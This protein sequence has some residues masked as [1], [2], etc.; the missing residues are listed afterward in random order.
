MAFDYET[1]TVSG[2]TQLPIR[3]PSLTATDNTF[4]CT[5]QKLRLN[6]VCNI[7]HVHVE[8]VHNDMDECIELPPESRLAS[9]MDYAADKSVCPIVTIILPSV[10]GRVSK[11]DQVQVRLR[12]CPNVRTV[13]EFVRALQPYH[14]AEDSVVQLP[15][16]ADE[17]AAIVHWTGFGFEPE[18]LQEMTRRLRCRLNV[19]WI[20]PRDLSRKTLALVGGRRHLIAGSAIYHAARVLGVDLVIIDKPGHW[21]Q[22]ETMENSKH[23]K[24]FLETDMSEDKHLKDRILKSIQEYG[25][26]IHGIFTHSDEFFLVVAHVANVLGLP[27][28]PISALTITADKHKSRLMQDTPGQT[29]RVRSLQQLDHLLETKSFVPK[30]P[31]I[32]KPTKGWASQCVSKVTS[33]DDLFTAVEKAMGRHC[34]AAVIEPF[35]DGPEV[36][37]NFVLLNGEVL[38]SEVTDERPCEADAKG[39]SV[40]ATFTSETLS[41]PSALPVNEVDLTKKEI[42]NIL[43][44]MGFQTGVFHAEARIVNSRLEYR[45]L[46]EDDNV[47]D[48][49]PKHDNN[50]PIADA[51][52]RLLEVNTRPP[53]FSVSRPTRLVYGIDYFAVDILAVLGEHDR[54]RLAA[55]PF[56]FS[57]APLVGAPNTAQCWTQLLCIS[58]P[59]EGI[60]RGKSP[61]AKMKRYRYDLAKHVHHVNEYFQKGDRVKLLNEGVRVRFADLAVVSTVSRRDAVELGEQVRRN[62]RIKIE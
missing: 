50:L 15:E 3:N 56:D 61:F 55:T 19:A 21:L 16:L 17:A 10:S 23:R 58:V 33:P 8:Q 28:N 38:F 35:F 22:P 47:I 57:S 53:G 41:M 7:V 46:G 49:A 37:V 51:E 2:K 24:A 30:Y 59:A 18:Q 54:L 62:Y 45:K 27:S 36:D 60:V 44:K 14:R 39:A 40:D 34:T 42:R 9:I 52:C 48:L 11:A 29:C 26:P 32:V 12:G 43:E 6:D 1:F 5:W 13:D 4:H 25:H 20:C 31:L